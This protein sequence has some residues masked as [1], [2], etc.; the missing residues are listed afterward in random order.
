M[1]HRRRDAILDRVLAR[2]TKKILFKQKPVTLQ[3]VD[4]RKRETQLSNHGRMR[5]RMMVIPGE[6]T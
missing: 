1:W 3:E 6:Y 4:S 5:P 2:L